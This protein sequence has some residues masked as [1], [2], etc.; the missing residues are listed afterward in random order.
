MKFLVELDSGPLVEMEG[1]LTKIVFGVVSRI[2]EV[3]GDQNTNQSFSS[4]AFCCVFGSFGSSVT[5]ASTRR[6][7]T[8]PPSP[9]PPA[10]RTLRSPTRPPSPRSRPSSRAPAQRTGAGSL[11]I[12]RTMNSGAMMRT[13]S[14]TT[15]CKC[16]KTTTRNTSL[17][18]GRTTSVTSA[19]TSWRKRRKRFA[20]V[21]RS[22]RFGYGGLGRGS[23]AGGGQ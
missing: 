12:G 16:R 19:C 22:G 20:S 23:G 3:E 21:C 6:S 1:D 2:P 4:H 8:R 13:T 5:A 10:Q 14:T 11:G 7:P 17:P 18:H 9:R 15:A